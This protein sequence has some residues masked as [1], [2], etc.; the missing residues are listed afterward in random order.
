GSLGAGA[1]VINMSPGQNLEAPDFTAAFTRVN[2]VVTTPDVKGGGL[3]PRFNSNSCSSCH[4]QP[5]VGGSSPASNPLFGVYN[6]S[7]ATNTM[8]SFITK[9]GP[10]L[11]AL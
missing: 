1:F 10:V 2:T 11:A 8:P 4:A 6:L 5:A 9:S 7:G 3:G